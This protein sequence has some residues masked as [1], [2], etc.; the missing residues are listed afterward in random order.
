MGY[1]IQLYR[2]EVKEQQ[3][4]S[5]QD[6][7]FFEKTE[8]LLPFTAEQKEKLKSRLLKYG[9]HIERE[10]SDKI[11]FEHKK[12]PSVEAM[13]THHG[14]FFTGRGDGIMEISM[15]SSEFTDGGEFAKFDPQNDGWEEF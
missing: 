10:G 14:L 12:E 4:A 1:H 9:Y 13:L 11:V 3:M 6:V 2:K 8:N 7:E 15:T 5:G